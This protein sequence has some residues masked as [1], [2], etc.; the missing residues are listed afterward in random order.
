MEFVSEFD[1]GGFHRLDKK[2]V[3]DFRH[4]VMEE[5][6]GAVSAEYRSGDAKRVEDEVAECVHGG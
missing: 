1:A 6:E 4:G 5:S 3:H 2:H